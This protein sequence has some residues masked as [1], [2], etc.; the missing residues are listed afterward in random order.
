MQLTNRLC[1]L[2]FACLGIA[3]VA[4]MFVDVMDTDAAQYA[5]MSMEMLHKKSFLVI[6]DKHAEYLDKPPLLFWFNSLSYAILGLSNFSYKLPSV[7]VTIIGI[8]SVYRLAAK[9]YGNKTG[10]FAAL[11]LASSQAF[12]LF[13]NDV[14]TDA[15]LTGFTVFA[16]WQLIEYIDTR[17][18]L[19]FVLGF[20]GIGLGMLSKGPISLIMVAFALGTDFVLKRQWKMIL[21]PQWI[22]GLLITLVV[23]SPM[24]L[25]LYMQFDMHP[26]KTVNGLK[27]VSGLRF[28][29][30]TQSFG[31]ITG[32]SEWNNGAPIEFFL[33]TF[34][35]AI[36]PWTLCFLYAFAAEIR[37]I[38]KS[39]F[40]INKDQQGVTIGVFVLTFIALSMSHYKLP[41][42]IFVVMPY[43]AIFTAQHL[44]QIKEGYIITR[45]LK[46]SQ[47]AVYALISVFG[48]FVF[49][50]IF[51][52]HQALWYIISIGIM[53]SGIVIYLK[54]K[55]PALRILL[56]GV[57]VAAGVNFGMNTIFYPKLLLYQTTH[58][59]ANE[60]KKRNVAEGKFY[61]SGDIPTHSLD[62]YAGY[63][64]PA[65]KGDCLPGIA[66]RQDLWVLT[67]K[68]SYHKM[69]AKTK[70][71]T[72]I[73]YTYFYPALLTLPFLNPQ[74]R[75]KETD[76]KYLLHFPKQRILPQ[77]RQ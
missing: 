43:A 13:N 18:A 49:F 40:K 21:R 55:E 48:C 6:T 59:A 41:H 63:L 37:T 72:A 54:E 74:T 15:M 56:G 22:L 23:L 58:I 36:L 51:P 57:L 65:L 76:K 69:A 39:R 33:H 68:D 26:E 24:M 34:L 29:F 70:P 17:K 75:H 64:S 62:F 52:S 53:L 66:S 61:V 14:R 71:D 10:R 8:Y 42:Y 1:Y 67:D 60:I 4:G 44:V 16:I 12:F 20:V 11:I 46:K 45:I 9:W 32:E 35:W 77:N 3:Y 7:L 31:R 38:F 2:L 19:N 30:W 28:F 5:S 73:E 47:L 27:N 25:G 50:Y